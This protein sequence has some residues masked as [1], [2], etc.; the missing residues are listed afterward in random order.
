MNLSNNMLYHSFCHQILHLTEIVD[1][2]TILTETTSPKLAY[3]LI[4][5]NVSEENSCCLNRQDF[6]LF[7]RNIIF[8]QSFF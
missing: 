6:K 5:Y 8:V 7:L 3:L 4:S 1:L 2:G